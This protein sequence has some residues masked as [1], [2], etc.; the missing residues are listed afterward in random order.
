MLKSHPDDDDDDEDDDDHWMLDVGLDPSDFFAP[1]LEPCGGNVLN[2]QIPGHCQTVVGNIPYRISSALVSKLLRQEPP[3][4]R[5]AASQ[6]GTWAGGEALLQR[7]WTCQMVV[8][9][10]CPL[11][12][13]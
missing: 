5:I 8:S 2:C 11:H 7:F 6:N 12:H 13:P 10:K 4:K 3:L 9:L 1:S